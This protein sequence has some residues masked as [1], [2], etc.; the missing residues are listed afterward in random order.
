M[1]TTEDKFNTGTL[2]STAPTKSIPRTRSTTQA[3]SMEFY[4]SIK[5]LSIEALPISASEVLRLFQHKRYSIRMLFFRT[6]SRKFML[7]VCQRS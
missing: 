4:T 6:K 2:I 5:Q 1:R 7:N 3:N